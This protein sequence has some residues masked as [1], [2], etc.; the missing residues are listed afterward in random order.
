MDSLWSLFIEVVDVRLPSIVEPADDAIRLGGTG[1]CGQQLAW[2]RFGAPNAEGSMP[3]PGGDAL[4]QLMCFEK[5]TMDRKIEFQRLLHDWYTRGSLYRFLPECVAKKTRVTGTYRLNASKGAAT[6]PTEAQRD[7]EHEKRIKILGSSGDGQVL[8]G[9]EYLRS[10]IVERGGDTTIFAKTERSYYLSSFTLDLTRQMYEDF[11]DTALV[12]TDIAEFFGR[13]HSAA[14]ERGL[15]A[16]SAPVRYTG[17]V[18]VYGRAAVKV[19]PFFD[20]DIAYREQ[21]EFRTVL[22]YAEEDEPFIELELGTLTGISELIPKRDFTP[23]RKLD[24]SF[25]D[26]LSWEAKRQMNAR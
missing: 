13:L 16:A 9:G 11:G 12:I 21:K 19:N 8:G 26:D 17:S 5:T 23:E 6:L 10:R 14:N 7:D 2:T 25:F 18:V 4:L 22:W 3:C 15:Q 20:K 1:A 24:Q